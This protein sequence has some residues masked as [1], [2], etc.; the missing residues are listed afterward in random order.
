M[1]KFGFILSASFAMISSLAA[2]TPATEKRFQFG[3]GPVGQGSTVVA[4]NVAYSKSSGFG[5]EKGAD[6]IFSESNCAA[7]KPF[8]FSVDLPEG[9]YRVTVTLGD[10]KMESKTTVKA[11]L[12]RLM[13]EDVPTAA[14]KS[15]TRSF[16]VNVRTPRIAGGGRVGLKVPRETIGEAWAWDDRLTLEFNGQR[17]ALT[18]LHIEKVQLPTVYIL[19]DS[20]VCDQ[21]KEP[22]ASW[23]QM[24]TRFFKPE[25]AVANHAESG[26][27]LRGSE[28]ARRFAKIIGD[29]K[30]GDYLL[31]QFGHNDMKSK[32]PNA[33]A[34]YKAGLKKWVGEVRAKGGIPVLITP[35]NRH[36][37]DKDK[38]V[39]SLGE[40]PEMVRQAANEEKAAMIDLNAKSKTFYEAFGREGS[41]QAFKHDDTSRFDP[42]H[43]SPYGAYELA[44]C[45]AVGLCEAKV[46]LAKHLVDEVKNF[47]PAKPDAVK[48][49]K[50]PISPNFTNDRPL[51][52]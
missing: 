7:D 40:Y 45:I 11:E 38:V 32:D 46:D 36:S 13:L 50:L 2:Q 28:S 30:A 10:A 6:L 21:S 44:K 15:T 24:L 9:N 51:G 49:F 29:M 35:M 8:Y 43:H 22:Y 17:P 16:I 31:V 23:G 47:D 48:D 37:F 42:T 18:T 39:N 4:S 52:D 12:R 25:V 20:T 14:G 26:E 34:L 1:L 19:G 5:F 3:T 33:V 41:I 27:S